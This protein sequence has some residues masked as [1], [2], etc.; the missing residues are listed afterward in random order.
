M[1][2]KFKKFLLLKIYLEI[3][4]KGKIVKKIL[5]ILVLSIL[6]LLL[7]PQLMVSYGISIASNENN[8]S[9]VEYFSN[10]PVV[11]IHTEIGSSV[12]VMYLGK[13]QEGNNST[14]LQF[15]KIYNIEDKK[16]LDIKKTVIIISKEDLLV[17]GEYDCHKQSDFSEKYEDFF[18]KVFDSQSDLCVF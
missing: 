15:E 18:M 6:P 1:I 13:I 7:L 2:C 12:A 5:T 8:S 14:V 3:Q 9:A 10:H 17:S 16:I 4:K 11:K